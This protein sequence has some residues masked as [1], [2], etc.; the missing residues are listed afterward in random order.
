M[1]Q[2]LAEYS[3]DEAKRMNQ[4]NKKRNSKKRNEKKLNKK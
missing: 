1:R 2:C 3:Q 4:N